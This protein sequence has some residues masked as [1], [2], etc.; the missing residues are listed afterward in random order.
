MAGWGYTEENDGMDGQQPRYTYLTR[1][2]V[3]EF[4]H[5]EKQS[6]FWFQ[7]KLCLTE[8]DAST[9][10][11]CRCL[12]FRWAYF[13]RLLVVSCGVNFD[14]LLAIA[15]QHRLQRAPR[16]HQLQRKTPAQSFLVQSSTGMSW[17]HLTDCGDYRTVSVVEPT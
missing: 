10:A 15:V 8:V 5:Y 4:G 1:N 3:H 13:E 9:L 17:I 16:W 2:Y 12:R 6:S 11:V 14:G 7:A